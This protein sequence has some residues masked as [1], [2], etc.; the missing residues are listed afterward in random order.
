M[1][2]ASEVTSTRTISVQSII[3]AHALTILSDSQEMSRGHVCLPIDNA[4]VLCR[5]ACN[6][7]V[8]DVV[9]AKYRGQ[10]TA[11][12]EYAEQQR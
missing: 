3:D 5:Y 10:N 6:W 1:V 7:V 11:L 2:T 4:N 9:Y 8:D 12:M